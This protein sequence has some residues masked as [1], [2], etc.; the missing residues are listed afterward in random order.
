MAL[1]AWSAAAALAGAP[2][3]AAPPLESS[4]AAV[5]YRVEQVTG[6]ARDLAGV[7]QIGAERLDALDV[8]DGASRALAACDAA[9]AR[10]CAGAIAGLYGA[11]ENGD[12]ARDPYARAVA[13]TLAAESAD[14]AL[15]LSSAAQ[16]FE[17]GECSRIALAPGIAT[18]TLVLSDRRTLRLRPVVPLR[19]G[20][21]YALVVEGL[22]PEEMASVRDSVVPRPSDGRIEVPSESYAGPLASALGE[23]AGEIDVAASVALARRLESGIAQMPAIAATPGVQIRLPKSLRAEDLARLRARFVPAKAAAEE[24]GATVVVLS[25]LDGRA[26]LREYRKRL[27]SL[28]CNDRPAQAL[29]REDVLG[30]YG[31]GVAL[32]A[33]GTYVSLDVRGEKGS[34]PPLG[35]TAEAA[36]GVELPYLLA[37]PE[38]FGPETPLVLGVDG[39]T[40]KAVRVLRRHAADL[41]R[42]GLGLLAIDMPEH[43]ERGDDP[44]G[45]LDVM[46]PIG[47]ARN[48]RQSSVDVMAAVRTALHCGLVLPDGAKLRPRELLYLGYSMGA[49]IGILTRAVEPDLGT[50]ALFAPA[51][52]V[53]GWLMLQVTPGLHAVYVSCLGGPEHG[54]S[55]F[56]DGQCEPPGRCGVDPYLAQ[57]STL[58]EQPYGL[59]AGGADP[60]E[61]ARSRTGEASDARLLLLTGAQDAVLYDVLQ[62]RLG[63][64]F[65]MH[66][67]ADGTFRG[68]RSIRLHWPNLGHEL[69]DR[70]EVRAAAYEFLLSRGRRTAPIVDNPQAGG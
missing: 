41:A 70:E 37:L 68:P 8:C 33:R 21:R 64:A 35:V 42:R 3:F 51:G 36:P 20:R 24:K 15:R 18:Q 61:F 19:A 40:G 26:G 27:S 39:H 67:A 65:G 58:L 62:S 55:C 38:G 25:V 66:P 11:L 4:P 63:D 46:D 31:G 69:V 30:A 5:A 10:A 45:F 6:R 48:L 59:A 29:D 32:I 34:A 22:A 49:M 1:V 44:K 57:L 47:V 56:P 28:A 16:A 2:A 54:K 53:P 43:G 52:D 17:A 12:E 9:F 13:W 50:M 60:L 14:G 7:L 23:D